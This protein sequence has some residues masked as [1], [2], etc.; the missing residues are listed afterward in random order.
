MGISI[1][2]KRYCKNNNK[3]NMVKLAKFDWFNKFFDENYYI[4]SF[5]ILNPYFPQKNKV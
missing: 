2:Y 5:H 1:K 3:E 4:S